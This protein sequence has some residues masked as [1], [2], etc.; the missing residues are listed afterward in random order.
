MAMIGQGTSPGHNL[1]RRLWK[2][3]PNRFSPRF[4]IPAAAT[5]IFPYSEIW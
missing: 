5:P 2:V 3:P 4:D 1:G